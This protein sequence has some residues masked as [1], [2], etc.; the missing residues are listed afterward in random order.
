MEPNQFQLQLELLLMTSIERCGPGRDGCRRYHSLRSSLGPQ[1][2]QIISAVIHKDIEYSRVRWR[3]LCTMKLRRGPSGIFHI[4]PL[5]CDTENLCFLQENRTSLQFPL[6]IINAVIF[7]SIMRCSPARKLIKAHRWMWKIKFIAAF[8]S[9]ID[10]DFNAVVRFT[11]ILNPIFMLLNTLVNRCHVA[12]VRKENSS[13]I[14]ANQFSF[15]C[16]FG[17]FDSRFEYYHHQISKLW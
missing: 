16:V 2:F 9:V 8:T 15:D 14:H 3:T 17:L 6:S 7:N 12:K 11:K 10:V 1:H 13:S 5:I 4:N